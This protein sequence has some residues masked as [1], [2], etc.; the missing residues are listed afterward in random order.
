MWHTP[1]SSASGDYVRAEL[2]RVMVVKAALE[3]GALVMKKETE[4]LASSVLR[5]EL[6]CQDV[7]AAL[8]EQSKALMARLDLSE[9]KDPARKSAGKRMSTSKRI[10]VGMPNPPMTWD[11]A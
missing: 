10:S 4:N 3:Q 5:M 8:K 6:R 2:H 11:T 1:P 7:H 9:A